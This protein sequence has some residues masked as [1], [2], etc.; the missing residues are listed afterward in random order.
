MIKGGSVRLRGNKWYYSFDVG[1]VDGKRKKIERVCKNAKNKQQAYMELAEAIQKYENG[2][3][4]EKK[5]EEMSASDFIDLW[6]DKYVSETLMPT[7]AATYKYQMQTFK[8][9]FGM[10]KMTTITPLT[11]QDFFSQLAKEEYAERTMKDILKALH[12]MFNYA[13][14]TARIMRYNPA[15]GVKIP[16]AIVKKANANRVYTDDDIVKIFETLKQDNYFYY[17]ITLI[18]YR[19]GMRQG[20]ILGLQVS[21]VDLNNKCIYINNALQYVERKYIL[22]A[23]KNKTS[24]RKIAIDDILHAELKEYAR[25]R[26]KN[27]LL[28]GELYKRYYLDKDAL[29]TENL[30]DEPLDFFIC[31]E[32][33]SYIGKSSLIS[34]MKTYCEKKGVKYTTHSFRHTHCVNLL[35]SNVPVKAIQDRLGHKSITTTL[36]MYAETTK[37][38]EE[39]ILETMNNKKIPTNLSASL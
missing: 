36:D 19:T 38:M 6:L 2:G 16:K 1:K 28:Y 23:P 20:E 3:T 15:D 27:K 12:S 17:I 37:K 8:K 33:G 4:T 21:D 7:T 11:I 26:A 39:Q 25:N 22:K 13:V 35:E 34:Y 29:I 10:Y 14:N 30:T 31:R 18:A 5:L 9:K 32:C 24:M